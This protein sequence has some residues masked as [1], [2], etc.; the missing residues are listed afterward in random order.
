MVVCSECQRTL[1]LEI[2]DREV[3]RGT[4][5]EGQL[6][7]ISRQLGQLEVAEELPSAGVPSEHL[8][9]CVMEVHSA[10]MIYLAVL[11]RYESKL[12]GVMGM[13]M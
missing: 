8:I 12:G 6:D 2:A 11:I 5:I 9:N 3:D 4:E 13:S 7:F 1:T 10:V